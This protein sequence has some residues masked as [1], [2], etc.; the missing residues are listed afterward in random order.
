MSGITPDR[1]SEIIGS[2]YDCVLA[3]DRWPSALRAIVNELQFANSAISVH[4]LAGAAAESKLHV[5]VGVDEEFSRKGPQ[6]ETEIQQ[7]WGGLAR[8]AGYPLEEPI[9]QSQATPR[10]TWHMNAWY[11]DM[12]VPRRLHDCATIFLVRDSMTLGAAAFGQHEQ[13]GE[14]SERST[15]A[16]RLIAPHLRRAV[17]I[18]RLFE[19]EAMTAATFSDVLEAIAAG[20]V[21]VDDG[22]G[23]VH[24]NAAARTMLT[25]GDPIQS[26]GGK[27]RLSNTVTNS[28]LTNAVA[29][30]ALR[31]SDLERRSIDIPVRRLDGTPIVIQVFPMRHRIFGSGVEQRTAAAVF[32]SNAADPPRLPADA[33]ALLYDLTPA[34]TRVFELVVEGRP[35]A[36]T[37]AQLGVSLATVRTHLSRVFEKTG[38]ARQADL[39]ALASKVTLTV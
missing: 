22:M 3:P 6:F 18:G 2:I 15:E 10:S 33:M 31:E 38:C 13:D 39:I 12:L 28:V 21:L 17:V 29:Q 24:A 8:L 9:I 5:A 20:T 14:I 30:A 25:K 4:D 16:L 37:A 27:L 26:R 35:P 23:I 19:Q 36:E 34:E 7:I 32:I 11:R 1:L